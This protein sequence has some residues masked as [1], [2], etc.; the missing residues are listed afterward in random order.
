M[1]SRAMFRDTVLLRSPTGTLFVPQSS[2]VAVYD[3]GTSNPVTD[4]LYF[5]SLNPTTLPNP[6]PIGAD[7]AIQFW[8]TTER[9]LDVV[10]STAGYV[11]VRTTVMTDATWT[12]ADIV[13]R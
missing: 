8:T 12:P 1:A 7:G 3:V 13:W 4:T 5:D 10:V 9:T 6:I 11:P 2:S